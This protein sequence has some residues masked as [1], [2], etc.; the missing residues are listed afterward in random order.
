MDPVLFSA[1]MFYDNLVTNWFTYWRRYSH[2]NHYWLWK[3]ES[4]FGVIPVCIFP[5]FSRIRT[6]YRD[7]SRISPYSVRM[8]E[9]VGEMQTR[10]TPNTDTFYAVSKVCLEPG[11]T[12]TME[13][14]SAKRLLSLSFF[15]K[16]S[17]YIG[18]LLSSK[19]A[20]LFI[21]KHILMISCIKITAKSYLFGIPKSLEVHSSF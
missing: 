5:A 18:L 6:Q 15:R 11:Q 20:P 10:T 12:S 8:Q 14:L 9:N 21:L 16:K 13:L 7:M 3:K 1:K 2:L 17:S 19:D 4:I